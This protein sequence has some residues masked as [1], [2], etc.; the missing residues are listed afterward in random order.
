MEKVAKKSVLCIVNIYDSPP[1]IYLGKYLNKSNSINLT[2][3]RLPPVRPSKRLQVDAFIKEEDNHPHNINLN[4]YFPLPYFLSYFTHYVINFF[5]FFYFLS[6]I[7]RKNFDIIIGG[8]NFCGALGYLLKIKFKSS[9][10]IYFNGDILPDI[11]SS[12]EC[13]FLPNNDSKLAPIVKLVDSSLIMMQSL[14]RKISYRNDLVWYQDKEIKEWDNNRRFFGKREIV[15]NGGI[16]NYEEYKKNNNVKKDMSNICYLGRI[17]DYVGLDIIIPALA[18][19]K[20]NIPNIK[21]HIIGGSEVGIRKYRELSIRVGIENNLKFY[22]YISQLTDV[23][24]IMSNCAL[25]LAL[26]KPVYDNSSIYVTQGK[27]RDYLNTGLPVLVTKNGPPLGKEIVKCNAGIESDFDILSVSSAIQKVLSD[28][29]YYNKLQKGVKEFV[30]VND[31]FKNN[32][33]FW[34]KIEK[35]Y[36]RL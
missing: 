20:K 30:Q 2:I 27:P 25:G 36:E 21:L 19:L 18:I 32:K 31:Y 9:L 10:S 11:N 23:Y 34:L 29:E 33:E 6:K 4:L 3:I 5:L 24:K 28:R 12:K 17:D 13:Y 14:L 22:G 8:T 15:F 1:W 16:T 26:Y 7:K 35:I